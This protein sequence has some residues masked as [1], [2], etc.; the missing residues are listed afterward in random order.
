MSQFETK[1]PISKAIWKTQIKDHFAETVFLTQDQ[2]RS[3]E[4][5][6]FGRQKLSQVEKWRTW[7]KRLLAR[8]S[9]RFVK[10]EAKQVRVDPTYALV[11]EETSHSFNEVFGKT[12]RRPGFLAQYFKLILSHSAIAF[13]AAVLT[14]GIVAFYYDKQKTN[15]DFVSELASLPDS[16]SMPPDFDLVGDASA[17][18]TLSAESLEG[19]AFQP[20]IPQQIAQSYSAYEGR[21]FQM[22]GQQGVSIAME[23]AFG[24]SPD[25][26]STVMLKHKARPTT[27]YI[28]KLSDK[29]S[30]SFPKEKTLHKIQSALGK[31][32]RIYAWRDGA[33]GYAMVQLQNVS[34]SSNNDSNALPI[35]NNP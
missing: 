4:A 21:F 24:L 34:T 31:M 11:H 9:C 30:A 25:L 33:Y 2:K 18:P 27:L 29:N 14:F 3:F 23:P 12:T 17:L 19:Q 7:Y 22:K 28:V 5:K 35:G 26:L 15:H 13:A 32:K 20:V 16:D 1:K 8:A 6:L 10:D